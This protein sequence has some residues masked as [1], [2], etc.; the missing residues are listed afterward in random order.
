M[1]L[2]ESTTVV[3]RQPVVYIIPVVC[4]P[5]GNLSSHGHGQGSTSASL[6]A[7]VQADDSE[8]WSRLVRLYGPVVYRWARQAGLQPNDAAD[9][10]QAVF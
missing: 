10:A 8:A 3:E 9:V 7:R 5:N 1:N 2:T 6:L 4:P